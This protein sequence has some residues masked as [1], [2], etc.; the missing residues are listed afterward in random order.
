MAVEAAARR[1]RAALAAALVQADEPEL[2]LVHKWLDSWRGV[3]LLAV[4]L[5]SLTF[6]PSLYASMRQPSIFSSYTQPSRWK[7]C[8]TCVACIEV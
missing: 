3:G 2:T 8:R 1:L 4:G 5:S 7:G 6:R